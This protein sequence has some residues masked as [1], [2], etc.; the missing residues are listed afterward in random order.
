MKEGERKTGGWLLK[1]TVVQALTIM[2][3]R[4]EKTNLLGE[5]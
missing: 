2:E 3:N 4:E 1:D 5:F